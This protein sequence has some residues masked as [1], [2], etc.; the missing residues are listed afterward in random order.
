MNFEEHNEKGNLTSQLLTERPNLVSKLDFGSR[1][2]PTNNIDKSN[3]R[4]L[5]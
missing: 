3:E 2:K 1:E 5:S 4:G